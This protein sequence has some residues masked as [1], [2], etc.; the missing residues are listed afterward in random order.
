MQRLPVCV[1]PPRPAMSPPRWAHLNDGFGAHHLQDLPAAAGAVGQH[2]VHDLSVLGKLEGQDQG[3]K[4]GAGGL[5]STP[6][7]A[8]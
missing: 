4:D 1:P 3:E 7:N 6:Q 5:L 2:E 8:P